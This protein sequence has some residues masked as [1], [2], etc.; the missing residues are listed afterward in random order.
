MFTKELKQLIADLEGTDDKSAVTQRYDDALVAKSEVRN[1]F[2]S[3]FGSTVFTY[4][5]VC[6]GVGSTG[7]SGEGGQRSHAYGGSR[8]AN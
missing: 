3:D 6:T 1:E 7:E 5:E 4:L 2:R 8:Q